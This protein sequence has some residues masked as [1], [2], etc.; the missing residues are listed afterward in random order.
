[1]FKSLDSHMLCFHRGV[2]L[3]RTRRHICQVR[4]VP[5]TILGATNVSYTVVPSAKDRVPQDSGA[6]LKGRTSQTT[7]LLH[8]SM[9]QVPESVAGHLA[10]ELCL[11]EDARCQ[12]ITSCCSVKITGSP[13][14]STSD[15]GAK[16]SP[17]LSA[18][19]QALAGSSW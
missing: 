11:I 2:L 12:D 19:H 18:P 10:A 17:S 1:M 16:R 13:A 4:A 9:C 14:F 6:P 8:W 7:V 15:T 5:P 3:M